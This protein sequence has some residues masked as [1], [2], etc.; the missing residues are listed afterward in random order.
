MS[1]RSTIV[2][3]AAT[4]LLSATPGNATDSR[5]RIEV[6]PRISRAP[7]EVRIRAIVTPSEDNRALKIVVD[8]PDYFRSSYV[9]LAGADAA[10]V[11]VTSFKNLPGGDYDVSVTLIDAQGD[12]TVDHRTIMVASAA[13]Q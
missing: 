11:T 9:Q 7:A 3:I 8:S 4:T 6:T 10:S 13:S 12:H 2:L 5:L 1:M